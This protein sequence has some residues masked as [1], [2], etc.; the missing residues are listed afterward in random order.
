MASARKVQLTLIPEDA[1]AVLKA[2]NQ[3]ECA[4][5]TPE[6]VGRLDAITSRLK[7]NMRNQGIPFMDAKEEDKPLT[8]G[9]D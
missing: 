2:L 6:E 4:A 5:L 7:W 3:D 9:E 1:R 8:M